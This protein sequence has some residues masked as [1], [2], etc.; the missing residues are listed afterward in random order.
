MDILQRIAERRL[1]E[2]VARGEFDAFSGKGEPLALEDL[3][4]VPEELRAGYLVLK[5]A[6]YL[7]EELELRHE[8]VRLDTL[9]AACHADGE[10]DTLRKTRATRALQLALV[11]E[12]RGCSP[13]WP[14]FAERIACRV[15]GE[16][17]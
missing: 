14:Q 3:S 12:R 6:G 7:P 2:A 11:M 13:A 1:D 16:P 5:G 17:G 15:A 9:L 4:G 10:R 8:L